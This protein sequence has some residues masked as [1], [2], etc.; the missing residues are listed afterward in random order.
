M[1]GLNGWELESLYQAGGG[2]GGSENNNCGPN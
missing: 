2:G 1:R